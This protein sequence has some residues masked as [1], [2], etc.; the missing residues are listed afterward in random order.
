[1]RAQKSNVEICLSSIWI[2]KKRNGQTIKEALSG[3]KMEKGKKVGD[4]GEEKGN[5][6]VGIGGLS[7]ENNVRSKNNRKGVEE[8]GREQ[9]GGPIENS[10]VK[11]WGKERLLPTGM[12]GSDL[13]GAGTGCCLPQKKGLKEWTF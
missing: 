7:M 3:I 1:V 6:G 5:S 8:S 2:R 4:S 11:T 9:A 10:V 12:E 13:T